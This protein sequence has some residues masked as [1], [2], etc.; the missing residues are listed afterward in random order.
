MKFDSVFLKIE[1]YKQDNPDKKC[2][3]ILVYN[4]RSSKAVQVEKEVLEPLKQVSGIMLGK[5]EVKP[6]NVDDNAESL[7]KILLDGDIVITA[8]GDGT[9]TIGLNGVV[10]SKRDVRFTALPFGNFNDMARTFKRYSGRGIYPL[11]AKINGEHYRFASCYFTIGMFAEST[12]IFDGDKMR[13]KLQKKNGATIYSAWQLMLW[14]FK[15]KRRRFIP[16]F[17]LNGEKRIK[18]SDYLAIN[19]VSVAKFMKGSKNIA[20]KKAEF[21]S[22][23]GRLTSFFRLVGFMF[24]SVLFKIPGKTSEKD[25]ILFE[26]EAEVEIQAEGE[27]KRISGISKIEISKVEKPVKIL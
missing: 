27:Y 1:K 19:G 26:K 4:P 5:Y 13:K 15:N 22:V 24:R 16:D 8:G 12:E 18:Q 3:V 21:I 9:A 25:V 20:D 14:Y 11:E 17:S 2:R 23:S 7:S 10:L 6:T